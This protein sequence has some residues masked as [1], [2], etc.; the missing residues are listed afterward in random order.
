MG[1]PQ[2]EHKVCRVL[3]SAGLIYHELRRGTYANLLKSKQWKGKHVRLRSLGIPG[4]YTLV[5]NTLEQLLEEFD[6]KP[7]KQMQNQREPRP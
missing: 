3:H 2:A 5:R 7:I 1:T 6:V 4:Q